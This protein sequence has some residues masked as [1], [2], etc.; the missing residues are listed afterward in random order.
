M[1]FLSGAAA[2]LFETLWFQQAGLTFGNSVWASSLVLAGFMGGLALGSGLISRF[3]HRIARPVRLY[4]LLEGTIALTGV[5][6]VHLLP[7]LI[8]ILTPFFRPFAEQPWILNPLRLGAA[9]AVLLI[10]STAMGATLPL[11][12]AA[13]YRRDPRFGRVLGL[14][15]GWNTAG[16]VLGAVAGE[17]FLVGLFGIRGSAL[18]AASINGVA[19]LLALAVAR[20]LD[21]VTAA[22]RRSRGEKLSGRAQAILGAALVFGG[23]LLALEVVWFRLLVLKIHGTSLT[24]S[25]MLATVLTGIALGSMAGAAWLSRAPGAH[26]GLPAL[27]GLSGV[28][29]VATYALHAVFLGSITGAVSEWDAVLRLAVPLMLPVCLL[30]GALFTLLAEALHRE[31]GGETRSAGLLTLANTTGAMLGPLAG[32]FLLLPALGME[33]SFAWLAAAYGA[34]ALVLALAGGLRPVGRSARAATAAVGGLYI[35]AL[36]FFPRGFMEER[37]LADTVGRFPEARVVAVREGLTETAIYL[38]RDLFGEPFVHRLVTNSFGMSGTFL[39]AQRY[40]KLFVY[41]PVA[42]HPGPRSAL[43]ISYGVGTTAKALTDTRELERIDVVDI[44]RDILE[45]GEIVYPDPA[46]HPLNDPRVRVHVEDGRYFLQTTDQRYDLITAE[47]PPPGAAGIVNLYTREYFALLH[48]RLSAGGIATYWL[49]VHS[50]LEVEAKAIIRAYC[51]VFA[52]CSLWSGA[53][54]NWMLVGTRDAR[55]PVSEA[56]FVQQWTDP[57]VG[58]ELRA[59]GLEAPAQLG[60]LY[61]LGADELDA[62]THA[63]PPLDDDH[64]KRLLNRTRGGIQ[65]KPTWTPWLDVDRAR[66]SFERSELVARLWPATIRAETYSWFETRRDVHRRFL[67][68]RS[69]RGSERVHELLATTSLRTLPLW[70]VG[71]HELRLRAARAARAKGRDDPAIDFELALGALAER[72]WDAA[73]QGFGIARRGG[74]RSAHAAWLEVYALCMAGRPGDARALA[75]RVRLAESP[76]NERAV[77]DFLRL[78]V[79]RACAPSAD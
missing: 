11:L 62:T 37:Y 5:A 78:R 52:D 40:M 72:D 19:L 47:P 59:L 25:V 14:L 58:P 68:I 54:L 4:A 57:V 7:H 29:C 42:V 63:V 75:G 69:D 2:L 64:P 66:R 48:D 76:A 70:A 43:L 34:A 21:A 6:L 77:L 45:L 53:G 39:K 16:A 36:V 8:P 41:W 71:S 24:F 60:T 1:F 32:G 74:E 12:V 18:V 20:P 73:A 15:Y 3:G 35:A 31:G 33:R 9:F 44:S 65:M 51:D 26:R 13:L 10:P 46:D 61:M 30:S 23:I 49:P 55:G 22:A 17:A 67:D 27:A 50:L 38:Q 56:R 28:A 79:D